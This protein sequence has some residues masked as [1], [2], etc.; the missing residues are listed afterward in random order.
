MSGVSGVAPWTAGCVVGSGYIP[1]VGCTGATAI[2]NRGVECD[3]AGLPTY[4]DDDERP[5]IRY[6]YEDGPNVPKSPCLQYSNA[7]IDYVT[8]SETSSYEETVTSARQQASM[9][10]A[11]AKAEGT[12]YGVTVGASAKYQES[13]AYSE[14]S[15]SFV[16]GETIKHVQELLVS[17]GQRV[18]IISVQVPVIIVHAVPPKRCGHRRFGQF[19]ICA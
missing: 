13:K 16:S 1:G 5:C 11:V 7:C 2:L 19:Q 12:G 14:N 17:L 8:A 9:M 6:E 18:A 10:E 15:V 3:A 4:V